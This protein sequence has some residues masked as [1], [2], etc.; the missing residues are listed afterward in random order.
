MSKLLISYINDWAAGTVTASSE[1]PSFPAINSQ[2]RW[3]KKPWRSRY[4]VGSGWGLFRI[5][6]GTS[7]LYFDEGGAELTATITAGDYNADTLCAE[8]KTQMEAAGAL[9][10]TVTH[11]DTSKLFAIAG[12]GNFSL[13][14]STTTNAIWGSIGWI[15]GVDT[16]SAA[17]HTAEE[18]RIHTSEFLYC[19]AG[20]TSDIRLVTIKGHNLQATATITVRYYSDAFVTLVDSEA[21]TWHA[22]QIAA[23]TA[24]SYAYYSI[25]IS[26]PSN[27]DGFVEIGLAWIGSASVLHYGFTMDRSMLP[28]DPSIVTSSDDGQESTIQ[29]TKY[30][31]WT[32]TFEAVE[33]NTDK[34]LLLAIFEEIGKTRP[35]FISEAPPTSGDIGTVAEYVTFPEWEWSHIAGLYWAL[36]LGVRT[37]R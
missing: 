26:D 25:E 36:T 34:P 32:Y 29:L 10:Y 27:A 30:K 14:L 31:G 17:A 3:H 28:E 20:K 37:Q 7:K 18:L 35:C 21:L 24:K 19:A 13:H 33:P 1:H 8:I 2:H 23:R 12:S 15:S 6:A 4:G 16:A 22:G 5:I 9:T 11:D